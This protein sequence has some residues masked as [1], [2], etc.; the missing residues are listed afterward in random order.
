YLRKSVQE[1]DES[2]FRIARKAADRAGHPDARA[3]GEVPRQPAIVDQTIQKFLQDTWSELRTQLGISANKVL[4]FFLNVIVATLRAL[5]RDPV[6][7]TLVVILVTGGSVGVFRFGGGSR[8]SD[9][10]ETPVV[11]VHA[12]QPA[13]GYPSE[14][15]HPVQ[16]AGGRP[17]SYS[18]GS[19]GGL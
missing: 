15:V 10:Y 4:E 11:A 6:A 16:P 8:L 17:S 19:S 9:S 2:A 13:G 7:L 5:G 14:R 1:L 3:G 18:A 12:V